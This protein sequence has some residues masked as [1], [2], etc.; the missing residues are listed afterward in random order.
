MDVIKIFL[1]EEEEAE[2]PETPETEG[3]LQDKISNCSL[4]ITATKVTRKQK[5]NQNRNRRKRLSKYKH[6]QYWTQKQKLVREI[7]NLMQTVKAQ[8]WR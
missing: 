1:T 4:E 5:K 7:N 6:F 2:F 8:N 3:E